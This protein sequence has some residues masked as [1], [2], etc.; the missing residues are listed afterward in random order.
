L[1]QNAEYQTI[2]QDL[3]LTASGAQWNHGKDDFW[4]AATRFLRVLEI[5][6]LE[7]QN[8]A[9]IDLFDTRQKS[10]RLSAEHLT[11]S[12]QAIEGS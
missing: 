11:P 6:L 5:R 1:G 10:W 2:Q 12:R 8:S 4:M 9:A 3:S 7:G